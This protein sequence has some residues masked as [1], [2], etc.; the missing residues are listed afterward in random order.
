MAVFERD[1]NGRLRRVQMTKKPCTEQT[2]QPQQ[3]NS[4]PEPDTATGSDAPATPIEPAQPTNDNE[5]NDN[6]SPSI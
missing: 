3:P 1:K 6:G 2:G 4:Q 5:V